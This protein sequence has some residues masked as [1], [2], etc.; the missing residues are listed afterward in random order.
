M[1]TLLRSWH[2]DRTFRTRIGFLRLFKMSMLNSLRPNLVDAYVIGRKA[3]LELSVDDL[4]RHV[5]CGGGDLNELVQ[6]AI[7]ASTS[8]IRGGFDLMCSLDLGGLP[9][10]D[11]VM[12]FATL[13]KQ[14]PDLDFVEFTDRCSHDKSV[15]DRALAGEYK[16]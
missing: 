2:I 3:N 14:F 11:V 16:P 13:R 15:I 10:L 8:G 12:A 1:I 6:A 9:V 4:E 7:I 5:L